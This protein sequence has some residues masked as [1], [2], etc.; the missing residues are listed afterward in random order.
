MKKRPT[1][2]TKQG[3]RDL[4]QMF[5]QNFSRES[6]LEKFRREREFSRE[7]RNTALDPYKDWEDGYSE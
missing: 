6:D 5:P 2:S 4:N 1:S 3:V 7:E